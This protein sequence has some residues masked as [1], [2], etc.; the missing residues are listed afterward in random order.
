MCA[1]WRVLSGTR[2]K[3]IPLPAS[4]VAC[5]FLVSCCFLCTIEKWLT[6]YIQ[7]TLVFVLWRPVRFLVVF[8]VILLVHMCYPMDMNYYLMVEYSS[9]FI[10]F[11]FDCLEELFVL[12][13]ASSLTN[14]CYYSRYSKMCG[15]FKTSYVYKF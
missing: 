10:V 8:E 1:C 4:Q 7:P 9:P 6:F 14:K 3:H 13:F 12:L 15:S 2:L 5:D 11:C